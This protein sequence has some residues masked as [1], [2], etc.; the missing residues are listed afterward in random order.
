ETRRRSHSACQRYGRPCTAPA[1]VLR[2]HSEGRET[3]GPVISHKQYRLES[4]EDLLRAA[5]LHRAICDASSYKEDTAVPLVAFEA[6]Y[7]AASINLTATGKPMIRKVHGK[8]QNTIGNSIFT[9]ASKASF[10]ARRKRS[11][12]RSSD[13][14]R[15]KG[16]RLID[17]KS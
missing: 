2:N 6:N 14:A 7:H 17:R 9:G 16:P 5:A 1:T 8:M 12:R 4:T 11:L 15:N 13:W 3:K 10:S